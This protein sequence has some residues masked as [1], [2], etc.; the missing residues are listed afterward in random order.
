[1][2]GI[3]SDIDTTDS[4]HEAS[5]VLNEEGRPK[6][7]KR[8]PTRQLS[9]DESAEDSNSDSDLEDCDDD[10]Q[11]AVTAGFCDKR[12]MCILSKCLM[13]NL[14]FIFVSFR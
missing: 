1:L 2:A 8:K 10:V 11:P 6:R 9:A 3:N 7:K 4:Q 5:S 14:K 13:Y 12:S